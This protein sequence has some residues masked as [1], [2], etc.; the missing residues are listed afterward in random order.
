MTLSESDFSRDEVQIR[1][2]GTK[3]YREKRDKF[4]SRVFVCGIEFAESEASNIFLKSCGILVFITVIA[5]R[6]GNVVG[7]IWSNLGNPLFAQRLRFRFFA[8]RKPTFI[9]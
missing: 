7:H 6:P 8:G 9:W 5:D 3:T 4:D 2:S 1:N